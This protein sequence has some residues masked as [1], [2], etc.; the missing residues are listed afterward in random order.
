MQ[1]VVTLLAYL[2]NASETNGNADLAEFCRGWESTLRD[3]EE[4]LRSAAAD[5]GRGDLDVA[6]A[7]LYDNAAGRA[8]HKL[9]LWVGTLGEWIDR[10]SAIRRA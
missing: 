8:G 6:V 2:G 1:H 9:Q 5:Q 7:P 4:R 10:R 3:A